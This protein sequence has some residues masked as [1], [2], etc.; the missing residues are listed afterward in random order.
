MSGL[1]DDDLRRIARLSRLALGDDQVGPCRERLSAVLGYV[2]RLHGLDLSGVEPLVHVGD[3]TNRL[4]ADEAG[5]T[6]GND[7][8]MRMA[9]ERL[10]PFVKVPKVIDEGAGA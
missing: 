4:A 5:Q 2:E 8:L 9:P 10:E 3:Q 7:V 6:L 1:S